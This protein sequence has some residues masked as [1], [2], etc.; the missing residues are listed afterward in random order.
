MNRLTQDDVNE[1]L[2]W[3]LARKIEESVTRIIDWHSGHNGKVFVSVSGG[4][5]S[6][7]VL[8]LVRRM[9]GYQDIPGIFSNTGLEFPENIEFIRSLPNI[10]EVRPK[11]SF[12]YVIKRFG[13]PVVSKRVAQYVGEAQ[14]AKGETATKRLRLTGVKSNGEFTRLGKIPDKWIP[15]VQADFKISDSSAFLCGLCV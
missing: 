9:A 11:R 7:V 13:Y 6:T 10:I 12:T 14:N 2:S 15:L 1:R 8:D 3:S 5:D 4:L